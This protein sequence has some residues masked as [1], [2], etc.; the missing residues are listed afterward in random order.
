MMAK[1]QYQFQ[2]PGII[3][4]DSLGHLNRAEPLLMLFITSVFPNMTNQMSAVKRAY[5]K[6]NM[7]F[8]Q[9]KEFDNVM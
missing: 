6:W 7:F 3:H 4:A 5:C 9:N 2:A 1:F 8:R